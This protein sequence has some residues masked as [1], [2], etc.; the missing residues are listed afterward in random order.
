MR[1]MTQRNIKLKTCAYG[2]MFHHF[3]GKGHSQAQGAISE[4]QF[5]CIIEYFKD[6]I[7]SAEQW[8]DKV[9]NNSLEPGDICLTF[10]D[11]L[12]SAYEVAV[13]V[14][15]ELNL[16]AFFFIYSSVFT[17]KIEMFEV[18]RKF[19]IECFKDIDHFYES[20]FSIIDKSP[21]Y[22]EVKESLKNYS[23]NQ[24]RHFPFYSKNDTK[25]RYIR[26]NILGPKRYNNIMNIM[27]KE[28][29]I[30]LIKFSSNLWMT[31]EHLK[32]LNSKGHIIGLHSHTHPTNFRM[33]NYSEQEREYK[34]NFDLL[35]NILGEKPQT[36]SHPCN[37]YNT[38]T[39]N[40]LDNLGIKVGFR[41]NMEKGVFSNLELPREDHA[42]IIKS[43]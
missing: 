24:F 17:G 14:L 30:D 5:R 27:I 33:L 38:S 16:T 26:D 3:I 34:L 1:I 7:L 25:F 43:I 31:V 21:Y 42:N 10:D 37:S 36:V 2:I 19:R 28:S 4:N 41:A 23:H 13:P 18:Y 20:F 12:L 9:L 40:I 22:N 15:H 39:L 32:K 29:N 35:H 6:N 11:A 8:Y